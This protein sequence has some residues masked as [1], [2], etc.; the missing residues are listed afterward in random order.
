VRTKRGLTGRYEIT[1]YDHESVRALVPEPLPPTPPIEVGPL[2]PILE[3]ATL[4]VG[5]LDSLSVLL[6]DT[7]IF[8]SLYVRKEAVLPSQI[9]GTRGRETRPRIETVCTQN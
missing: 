5:R 2:L 1:R 8:F 3:R 7:H 9:E 6:P 4:A